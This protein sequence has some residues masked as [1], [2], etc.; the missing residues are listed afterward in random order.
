M[1]SDNMVDN[2]TITAMG[3]EPVYNYTQYANDKNVNVIPEADFKRLIIDTFATIVDT[4]RST[5]GPYGS[6][7]VISEMNE[8][9]STKDGY[10]VFNA[11]RFSNPY[12]QMVYQTIAKIIKRVNDNVGDGTTSCMLLASELFVRISNVVNTADDKRKILNILTQIENYLQDR[13]AIESDMNDGVISRVSDKNTIHHLINVA[14][15]YDKKLTSVLMDAMK[16]VFSDDGVSVRNVIVDTEV[17]NDLDADATYRIDFMPGKYRVRVDLDTDIGIT[18][19]NKVDA[20]I[21]LFRHELRAADWEK[22]MANYDWSTRVLILSRGFSED[23]L[24]A[25]RL[26]AGRRQTAA[27]RLLVPVKVMGPRVQDEISDLAALLNIEAKDIHNGDD[28]KYEEMTAHTVSIFKGNALCFYN[29]ETPKEYVET[30]RYERDND[31]GKSYISYD[32]YTKRIN[33]LCLNNEDTIITVKAGSKLETEMIKDKID[34]CVSIVESAIKTGTVPNLLWYANHRIQNLIDHKYSDLYIDIL[35]AIKESI[36]GG[37][38]DTIWR[39]KYN[40]AELLTKELYEKLEATKKIFYSSEYTS[41]DIVEEQYV[42]FSEYPTSAQ[43]D[44]EV[45]VASIA[46][47]KYL[48]TSRAFIF[49]AHLLNPVSDI[50]RYIQH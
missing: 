41:Y 15:N 37:V 7:I 16:P 19:F 13:N 8:V 32:Q 36:H 1:R 40:N 12:K 50:G 35:E 46:I 14:S 42:N 27:E 34:D 38:F 2:T 20:K 48:I 4:L 9:M 17:T 43:Y 33:A 3:Y 24:H 11:M 6:T 31:A 39:S 45:L 28:I 21:L 49:D 47:V 22:I 18:M 23:F 44:L 25:W 5:Y 26:Y 30:L 29:V 10:N